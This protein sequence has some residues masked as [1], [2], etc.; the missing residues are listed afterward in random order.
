MQRRKKGNN[1]LIIDYALLYQY[2]SS[3]SPWLH[4]CQIM[5]A[6]CLWN[7][8][9]KTRQGTS[10]AYSCISNE[11]YKVQTMCLVLGEF[12][13]IINNI[14]IYKTYYIICGLGGVDYGGWW[15]D[16]EL[17]IMKIIFNNMHK[18]PEQGL[19]LSGS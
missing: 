19:N 7:I 11:R 5:V 15:I 18:S 6:H 2:Q 16:I 9:N 8:S 17:D 10:S 13:H 1:E 14:L 3:V 4:V 12:K